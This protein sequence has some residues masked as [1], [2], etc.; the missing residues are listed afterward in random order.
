M[1][2]ELLLSLSQVSPHLNII[3]HEANTRQSIIPRHTRA[4]ILGKV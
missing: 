3:L 1:S 4:L 2:Q